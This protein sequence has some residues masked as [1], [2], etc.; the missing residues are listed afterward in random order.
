[1]LRAHAVIFAAGFLGSVSFWPAMSAIADDSA[2]SIVVADNHCPPPSGLGY[3]P[4]QWSCKTRT[5]TRHPGEPAT[6]HPGGSP[7]RTSKRT[8]T[9]SPFKKTVSN[10]SFYYYYINGINTPLGEGY[11]R[12]NYNWERGLVDK[13]LV[14][15]I[16]KYDPR[17]AGEID[18]IAE[19]THNSSGADPRFE[20]ALAGFCAWAASYYPKFN[21]AECKFPGRT[22][23]CI[24]RDMNF[25]GT[26]GDAWESLR[27]ALPNSPYT[28]TNFSSK[29][30]LV[31]RIMGSMVRRAAN[32]QLRGRQ[33][34]FIVV[35][36]SQGNFIAE[37]LVKHIDK[38]NRNLLR[39]VGVLSLASPTNYADARK[40]GVALT[41]LTR[42]DDMILL[43]DKLKKYG[44]RPLRRP[45]PANLPP[46]NLINM[47]PQPE[48]DAKAEVVKRTKNAWMD[49]LLCLQRGSRHDQW[50]AIQAPGINS[51]IIDSY[52]LTALPA[53][54]RYPV[55]TDVLKAL[56]GLKQALR[57]GRPETASSMTPPPFDKGASLDERSLREALRKRSS[58]FGGIFAPFL[59]GL[60]GG[61]GSG[62]PS[63][64]GKDAAAA[65]CDRRYTDHAARQACRA[66]DLWGADRLQNKRSRGSERDWYGR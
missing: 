10:R 29:L 14:S 15:N 4:K 36:H 40:T 16:R 26:P 27:Q 61:S 22:M 54:G 6:R 21:I 33:A 1:M 62:R 35:A 19:R 53:P 37:G 43:L 2:N 32:D 25:S 51:H 24:R 58:G 12:G 7:G 56:V 38:S 63:P 59:K 47:V 3:T 45:A 66:G 17:S 23:D 52:L 8:G 55:L 42:K 65:R 44:V 57:T 48:M 39:R 11:G 41:M 46:F 60:G 18:Q 49:F 9:Q 28:G 30:K 5:Q 50:D 34:Y 20:P 64:T 31:R 13:H